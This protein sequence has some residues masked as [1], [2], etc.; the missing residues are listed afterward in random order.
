MVG[1]FDREIAYLNSEDV[2]KRFEA[3]LAEDTKAFEALASGDAKVFTLAAQPGF[4]G[5]GRVIWDQKSKT[6]TLFARD[7]PA[8]RKDQ[9]FELWFIK[10]DPK[11][12]KPAE[13]VA[14]G[15]LT[16]DPATG[17]WRHSAVVPGGRMDFD[18]GALTIEPADDPDPATPYSGPGG[19]IVI[20]GTSA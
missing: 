14:A 19:G 11:T 4:T 9:R 15:K 12:G 7:L 16:P 3:N 20:A 1:R 17:L 13:L 10:R 2:R 8:L 5:A 6:W 18:M